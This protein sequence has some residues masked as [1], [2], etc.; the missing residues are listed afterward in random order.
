LNQASASRAK[1]AEVAGL[2]AGLHIVVPTLNERDNIVRLIREI[3]RLYRA[4][5]QHFWIV[6]DDSDDGTAEAVESLA[7]EH[8]N[9]R[10]IRRP[11]GGGFAAACVT[12]M[13]AALEA[14]AGLILV[15]DADFSHAPE[16]IAGMVSSAREADLVIG[17][18]YLAD[19]PSVREWSAWR[20][21]LSLGGNFYLRSL[22]GLPARDA[23]SG[24]RLWRSEA[25][26]RIPLA[27][28]RSRGY[29]FQAEMLFYAAQQGLRI[30]EAPNL[31]RG[32]T[33][34]RSK[35]TLGM[36]FESLA[37]PFRLRRKGGAISA[38]NAG[39]A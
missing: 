26:R 2:P 5:D 23:T 20:L 16:A 19:S 8:P 32:R 4:P 28:K 7:G 39:R 18:R 11:R 31:Y 9:A 27:E 24:F 12:G 22:L 17:S 6:D 21:W 34:G 25:L 38:R 14:G 36:I 15:M 29:S 33:W 30:A 35:M 1:R 10:M 3:T 13:Q 37:L